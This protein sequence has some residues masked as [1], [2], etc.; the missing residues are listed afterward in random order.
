MSTRAPISDRTK[1]AAALCLLF[2]IPGEDQ[3]RMHE[4]HVLSLVQWD[5]WPIRKADG[6]SDEF[7]NLRPLLIGA[8][9]EKTATV[10]VPAIAKGKRIQHAEAIHDATM[11]SK[12]GD[13]Q[14]AAVILS[15][16]KRQ[17]RKSRSIPSRPFPKGHRPLRS[18]GFERRERP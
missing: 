1:L 8:H 18:R 9:R 12:A 6:G 14:G 17:Q 5:H 15:S 4:D 10:D 11:A 13:Y 3:K 7:S 16:V 2:D